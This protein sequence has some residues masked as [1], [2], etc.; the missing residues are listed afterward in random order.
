MLPTHNPTQTPQQPH[1]VADYAA[2]Q[3]ACAGSGLVVQQGGGADRSL[4]ARV[5]RQRGGLAQG[6]LGARVAAETQ[7]LPGARLHPAADRDGRGAVRNWGAPAG[8]DREYIGRLLMSG[9]E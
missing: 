2:G 5:R 9:R 6:A 1:L 7:T 8:H 4:G 3:R